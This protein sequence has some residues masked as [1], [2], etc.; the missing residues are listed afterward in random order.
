MPTPETHD[1]GRQ[2]RQ[3]VYLLIIAVTLGAQ[4]ERMA[5][6]TSWQNPGQSSWQWPGKPGQY[7]PPHTPV[8]SANDRSRWCTVWSLVELGTFQI[9][10]FEKVP[11][12]RSIDRVKKDG[13]FYSSKPPLLST[14]VAGVY[15][16]LKHGFGMD[17]MRI[18]TV[19]QE[20]VVDW[21]KKPPVTRIYPFTIH[22]VMHGTVQLILVI[23]NLVPFAISLW[24]LSRLVERYAKSDLTRILVVT[25]AAWGTFLSTFLITLNNHTVA[26]NCILWSLCAALKVLGDGDLRRRWF[27]LAGFFAAFSVTC[28]LPS[29]IY[30]VW[31]GLLLFRANWRR[32]L[33]WFT[34]GAVVPLAAHFYL[35][36]LVVGGLLPFYASF[37]KEY[38]NYEGSYWLKPKGMDANVQAPWLYLIHCTIG[39]HGI[40]SLTP[41]FLVTIRTWIMR[42]VNV[43]RSGIK[44]SLAWIW[45]WKIP[46]DAQQVVDWL[47]LGCTTVILAFYLTRTNSYNYGGR[48]SGLRWAFWLIPLLLC[49]MIPALDACLSRRWF[50]GLCVLL[51]VVSVF[52]ATFPWLNPWTYPWLMQIMQQAGWTNY[53]LN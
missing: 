31:L 29:G 48:T 47:S 2:C 30:L 23:I 19:E 45:D 32:T 22:Q 39:H 46:L 16:C 3:W 5:N 49:S 50:R 28:E 20:M 14:C 33:T 10:Y 36:I 12:W 9:D 15:W 25:A 1:T 18:D 11:T 42:V 34:A 21:T 53:Q 44:S 37:G 26:A 24:L 8:L 43:I 35:N 6:L 40:F 7:K 51:L 17:L 27:L 13:H 52:S 41:L 4:L 38:Y